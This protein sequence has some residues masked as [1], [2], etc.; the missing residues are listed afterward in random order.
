MICGA[1]QTL[2]E[3]AFEDVVGSSERGG[4]GSQ[5]AGEI[6]HPLDP[7]RESFEFSSPGSDFGSG[8]H[9]VMIP[10]S[11]Y[12]ADL[13]DNT[14]PV[15]TVIVMSPPFTQNIDDTPL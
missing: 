14:D 5:T 7:I 10:T 3:E 6:L 9:T 13:T 2:N 15:P 4:T 12:P 1:L 11:P 8:V